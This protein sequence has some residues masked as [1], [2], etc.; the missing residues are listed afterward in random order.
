MLVL[1]SNRSQV[2]EWSEAGGNWSNASS[3]VSGEGNPDCLQPGRSLAASMVSSGAPFTGWWG[4]S[5]LCDFVVF[6]FFFPVFIERFP[7]VL[8]LNSVG[9]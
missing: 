4:S 2:T 8:E 9:K 6:V 5:L 3:L 1:V 7:V